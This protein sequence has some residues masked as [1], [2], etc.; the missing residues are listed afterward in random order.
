VLGRR[1]SRDR[2]GAGAMALNGSNTDRS[3]LGAALG[4][5]QEAL[6]DERGE[7]AGLESGLQHVIVPTRRSAT[8][9]GGAASRRSR[10]CSG[11]LWPPEARIAPGRPLRRI[12]VPILWRGLVQQRDGRSSWFAGGN[13]FQFADLLA[14]HVSSTIGINR[15]DRQLILA[16]PDALSDFSQQ[17]ALDALARVGIRNVRLLWTPVA[18]ALAWINRLGH[19]LKL[20]SEGECLLVLHVGAGAVDCTTFRLREQLV[21]GDRYVVPIRR[22]SR[23]GTTCD[24]F[25]LAAGRLARSAADAGIEIDLQAHWYGLGLL[26][27]WRQFPAEESEPL[28]ARD[29]RWESVPRQL[30]KETLTPEIP[31]QPPQAVES[32]LRDCGAPARIEEQSDNW[33]D[34]VARLIERELQQAPGKLRGVIIAGVPFVE[35]GGDWLR[36]VEERVAGAL[37]NP[38]ASEEP[39]V[40]GIWNAEFGSA[41]IASGAGLFGTRLRLGLPTY[42]DT[43]PKFEVYASTSEGGSWEPL[44]RESEIS[45]GDTYRNVIRGEFGLKRDQDELE[46]F[47]RLH[48]GETAPIRLTR[49]HFPRGPDRPMPLDLRIEVR[50]AGG[51]AVVEMVPR[52]KRFLGGV[53]VYLDYDEMEE[54]E[55]VPEIR[56][57][58]PPTKPPH[59][60]D[61]RD[62]LLFEDYVRSEIDRF[63]S[64]DLGSR[65]YERDLSALTRRVRGS[66]LRDHPEGDGK[67]QF[68]IVDVDGRAATVR[69]NDVIARLSRKIGDDFEQARR[70][71]SATARKT[72]ERLLV[73]GAWLFG[74]VP[75]EIRNH[76][77]N[78]LKEQPS[79]LR[80][81]VINAAGR[82]LQTREEMTSFFSAME[83]FPEDREQQARW[84]TIDWLW[85]A[86]RL[87]SARED[88][89]RSLNHD[90]TI[91]IYRYLFFDLQSW[92]EGERVNGFGA[93]LNLLFYLLRYRTLEGNF[94]APHSTTDI[95]VRTEL[96]NAVDEA[97]ARIKGRRSFLYGRRK[98][99]AIEVLSGLKDFL[100][101]KGDMNIIEKLSEFDVDSTDDS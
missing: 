26:D 8:A 81:N 34:L 90:Q 85:S 86:K 68:R 43:L 77:V 66:V 37:A 70:S 57:G 3:V 95:E 54:V 32:L 27:A 25:D 11:L 31:T 100:D 42:L 80:R 55:A 92:I 56:L 50:P 62:S 22:R 59:F 97:S 24:G 4:G 71:R 1:R 61:S 67:A 14:A 30:F 36:L 74:A 79:R 46:A 7:S 33:G 45:G 28:W 49:F 84:F 17:R 48:D 47:L 87:L 13:R 72:G 21:N 91:Q 44:V 82:T 29:G 35:G 16:I 99:T 19:R 83:R 73:A 2:G 64:S 78:A 5:V 98:T 76:V 12:P 53:H 93:T 41:V 9:L 20:A 94:L 63:L 101:L 52:D 60:V 10:V 15:S 39:R 51:L 96:L 65:S 69:G 23:L 18:L 58:F 89:G 40:D 75:D 6:W 38:A 88:A